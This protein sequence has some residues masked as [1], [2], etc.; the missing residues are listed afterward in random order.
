[1]NAALAATFRGPDMVRAHDAQDQRVMEVE[2]VMQ[3]PAT[4]QR[5]APEPEH[6]PEPGPEPE[7]EHRA[8]PQG[9]DQF[10][11]GLGED[12]NLERAKLIAGA[13]TVVLLVGMFVTSLSEAQS[14]AWSVALM[15][16]PVGL[17]IAI[18]ARLL[19]HRTERRL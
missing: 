5:H 14:P 2:P 7:C 11:L 10:S 16:L 15:I 8:L 19:R 3:T 1:M 17:V 18:S 12:R 6:A 4:S 13:V 9:A